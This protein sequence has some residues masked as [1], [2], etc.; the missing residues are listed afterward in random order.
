MTDQSGARHR[1]YKRFA[2]HHAKPD[3]TAPKRPLPR[4]CEHPGWRSAARLLRTTTRSASREHC[5][6]TKPALS[7]VF[8][9]LALAARMDDLR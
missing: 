3:W 7:S 4:E 6:S 1:V 9:E 2:P 5:S 8:L